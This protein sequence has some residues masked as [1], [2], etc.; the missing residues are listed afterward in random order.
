MKKKNVI[1]IIFAILFMNIMPNSVQAISFPEYT[2]DSYLV[3]NDY[4][5]C[6]SSDSV[7]ALSGASG[8]TLYVKKVPSHKWYNF[9]GKSSTREMITC[10]TKSGVTTL[11]GVIVKEGA[12]VFN[13]TS[14]DQSTS[15]SSESGGIGDSADGPDYAAD[16][17]KCYGVF[18]DLEDDGKTNDSDGNGIPSTGYVLIKVLNFIKFLG[19]IL[20]IAMTI[21]EG[22][23]TVT[24][25]DKDS[26]S[27]FGKITIKRVIYA[28]LL[29]AFPAFVN[30]IIKFAF[31]GGTCGIH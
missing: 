16:S 4:S 22:V 6:T 31:A 7:G 13:P 21:M 17:K 10:K 5:E 3:L 15:S 14:E 29:Y 12:T 11:V 1:F 20:V 19:P 18:G 27:K 24:S 28:V 9:L 23:K 30:F 2:V 26:L 25:N 8:V